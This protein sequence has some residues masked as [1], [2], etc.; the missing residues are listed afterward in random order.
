MRSLPP[1]YPPRLAKLGV[2]DGIEVDTVYRSTFINNHD[3]MGDIWMTDNL[4]TPMPDVLYVG[5]GADDPSLE[6]TALRNDEYGTYT[7]YIRAQ[8]EPEQPDAG[9][10]EDCLNALAVMVGPDDHM[11]QFWVKTLRSAL[12]A[13]VVD[14]AAM[15]KFMA[16]QLTALAMPNIPPERRAQWDAK[17]KKHQEV[18]DF[19]GSRIF[20][21][22]LKDALEVHTDVKAQTVVDYDVFTKEL[23][24]AGCAESSARIAARYVTEHFP[25]GLVIKKGGE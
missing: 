14:I 25:H 1:C 22:L 12:Q 19:I 24:N 11:G 21:D 9:S 8:P 13:H 18:A 16:Y 6:F 3:F 2:C 23:F 17:Q 10:P 7:K 4:N 5:L 20:G 15:Q